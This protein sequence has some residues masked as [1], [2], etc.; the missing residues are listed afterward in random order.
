MSQPRRVASRV[1]GS[2]NARRSVLLRSAPVERDRWRMLGPSV[3]RSQSVSKRA[4]RRATGV[5][6]LTT[7]NDC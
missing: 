2:V 1:V 5:L 6:P 3:Q 7:H 4:P